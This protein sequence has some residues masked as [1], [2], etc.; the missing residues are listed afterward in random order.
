MS[1]AMLR[2]P[3]LQD[4]WRDKLAKAFPVEQEQENNESLGDAQNHR[5]S[6]FSFIKRI[7]TFLQIQFNRNKA[8][9]K[10]R[11]ALF[12]LPMVTVLREGI[13]AMVF[14]GGVSLSESGK[15]IPLAAFC[16]ILC[17]IIIGYIIWRGGVSLRIHY[18]LMAS[19]CVL[20]LV[21]AGLASK[22][23]WFFQTYSY[24]KN[25]GFDADDSAA[26][27]DGPGS[28]QVIIYTFEFIFLILISQK[29][30]IIA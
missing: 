19:T 10:Q 13:E 22:A 21:A 16:G 24:I 8:A 12:L 3:K 1:L 15:S 20:L 28:F 29:L 18:F 26:L 6:L 17:G 30:R 7:K 2:V 14:M 5:Y 4:K 9:S 23:V 27:G 25:C 11:W